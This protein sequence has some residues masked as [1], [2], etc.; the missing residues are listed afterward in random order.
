ML[1]YDPTILFLIRRV[2][3]IAR[4]PIFSSNIPVA[5]FVSKVIRFDFLFP[6]FFLRKGWRGE[7]RNFDGQP[8]KLIGKQ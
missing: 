5:L 4:G 8:M 7:Q 3:R 6:V 2:G 1:G